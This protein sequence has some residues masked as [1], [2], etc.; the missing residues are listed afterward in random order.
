M[1]QAVRD[2]QYGL[3]CL[4]PEFD[5]TGSVSLAIGVSEHLVMYEVSALEIYPP[6]TITDIEPKYVTMYEV[7]V[8]E[9][10]FRDQSMNLE[11][12]MYCKFDMLDFEKRVLLT[13][14]SPV[15]FRSSSDTITCKA[16]AITSD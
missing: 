4:T 11:S 1:A 10:Q 9:M 15:F 14:V 16:P 8:L 7:P 6:I 5:S 13:D 3:K 2:G 12:D